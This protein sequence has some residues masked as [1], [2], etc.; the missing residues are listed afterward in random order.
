MTP[1]A[2]RKRICASL[3]H[4]CHPARRDWLLPVNLTENR[5]EHGFMRGAAAFLLNGLEYTL[6]AGLSDHVA[7]DTVVNLSVPGELV[8]GRLRDL[9]RHARCRCISAEWPG[10]HPCRWPLRSCRSGHRGQPLRPG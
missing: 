7:Q 10:V 6:A 2:G 9:C 5:R 3:M 1:A 4:G 8:V